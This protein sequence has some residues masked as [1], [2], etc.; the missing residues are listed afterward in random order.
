MDAGS[1]SGGGGG[2]GI[3]HSID[4]YC[5]KMKQKK[6]QSWNEWRRFCSET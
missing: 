4:G 5:C 3:T 6:D 2:D 1:G